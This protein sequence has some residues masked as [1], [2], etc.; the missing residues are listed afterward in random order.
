LKTFDTQ[1]KIYKEVLTF[2]DIV[3]GD[4]KS[5]IGAKAT[6]ILNKILNS[7]CIF[8]VN[9]KAEVFTL[10]EYLFL[11]CQKI[12]NHLQSILNNVISIE[13]LLT[14]MIEKFESFYDNVRKQAKECDL[15]DTPEELSQNLN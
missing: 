5:D 10:T 6:G 4:D 1:V 11:L 14:E 15:E 13:V 8:I 12:N 9:L 3:Q 7:K 2:L